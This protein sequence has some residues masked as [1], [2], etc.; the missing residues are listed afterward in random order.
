MT[1]T[2][3]SANF[4]NF[5]SLYNDLCCDLYRRIYI[6]RVAILYEPQLYELNNSAR[7]NL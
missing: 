7:V 2:N 6:M 3:V 5:S 1:Y 4:L